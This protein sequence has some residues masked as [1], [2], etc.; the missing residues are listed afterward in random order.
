MDSHNF[1][2]NKRRSK[3]QTDFSCCGIWVPIS[4]MQCLTMR[5][6]ID[7]TSRLNRAWGMV[8]HMH[9]A[10]QGLSRGGFRGPQFDDGVHKKSI[11]GWKM[12]CLYSGHDIQSISRWLSRYWLDIQAAC[13]SLVKRILD[14]LD[15]N[16]DLL[17][18]DLTLWFWLYHSCLALLK[19]FW[20]FWQ[21]C[22][23]G[24][25]GDEGHHVGPF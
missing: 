15:D 14:W 24:G 19:S 21:H 23:P 10:A 9:Q 2:K 20:L 25:A 5:L 6:C 12:S 18:A 16:G 8:S 13:W 22:G 4:V 11:F 17:T 7:A 1:F 3:I